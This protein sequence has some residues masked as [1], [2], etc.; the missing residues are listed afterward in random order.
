VVEPVAIG[1][2]ATLHFLFVFLLL[3][4]RLK[5]LRDEKRGSIGWSYGTSRERRGKRG[6][7]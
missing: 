7:Y 1:F 2:L 4:Y 6:R 5:P 3:F